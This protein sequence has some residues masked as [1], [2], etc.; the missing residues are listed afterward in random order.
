MAQ[1]HLRIWLLLGVMTVTALLG[2][3]GHAQPKTVAVRLGYP[4]DAKLL[5]IHADDLALAHSVDAASFAALDQ[6]AATSASVMVTCPWLTEVAA[7]A[8]THPEA[9][10]GIH[11][12]LTSEWETYRWGSVAPRDQVPSLFDAQGYLWADVPGAVNHIKPEEAEREVRAQVER[13]LQLGI[14]PTHLDNHMGTLFT[15][16]ALLAVY[17]KVAREYHLPFLAVRMP[18]LPTTMLSMLKD[19]DIVLDAL[20]FP[21]PGLRPEEWEEGYLEVI[22]SLKPGLNQLIVHLGYDDA[23][24]QAITVNHPDFGAAWRQRDFNVITGSRFKRALEE[25]RVILVGWKDL[26][27]LLP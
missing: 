5:I 24:L 9:D 22:R 3:V 16:P 23:E 21:R 19:T 8:K 12:T 14:R 6:K 15:H 11:T 7:Y 1:Q 25:N 27:K 2:R 26:K 13:A 17:L 20:V 10:L 18:N 4:A